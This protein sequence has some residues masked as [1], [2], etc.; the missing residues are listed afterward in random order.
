MGSL[1]H[2]LANISTSSANNNSIQA[3]SSTLI[4]NS[5]ANNGSSNKWKFATIQSG[6]VLPPM[7]SNGSNSSSL[8]KRTPT[9]LNSQSGGGGRISRQAKLN[10][11]ISSST[12]GS[13]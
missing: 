6:V 12:S 5:T 10:S 4:N 11:I 2:G 1:N 9:H 7:Q 13:G 8:P 3:Q